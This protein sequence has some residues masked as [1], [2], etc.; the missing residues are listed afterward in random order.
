MTLPKL[1]AKFLQLITNSC[2]ILLS[3]GDFKSIKQDDKKS[4]H[5][6]NF[7]IETIST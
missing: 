2:E 3:A 7:L 4:K 5:K 6:L 1:H